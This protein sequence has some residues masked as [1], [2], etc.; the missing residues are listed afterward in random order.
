MKAVFDPAH[1]R[2]APRFFLVRGQLQ[3]STEQPERANRLLKGLE[4]AEI[5]VSPPRDFGTAPIEAVHSA[6]YLDFIKTAHQRWHELPNASEEVIANI[7][8]LQKAAKYPES[9]IG[10]AGWHMADTACPI[11]KY[12]W[13]AACGSANSALTATQLVLDGQRMSYA[14]CR[15]PGHHAYADMAGGFCFLNN[16]AIAAQYA[17]ATHAR[18]AILDVDV[19]HGNGTQGIFY[20]RDDVLTIS[21]HAD[22]QNF[23]PFYWGHASEKGA[24]QGVGFNRN[25]PLPLLSADKEFLKA[26]EEA[27]K[28]VLEFNPGILIIALGLDASETD[29]LR[30]LSVTTEG[31]NKIGKSIAEFSLPTVFIQEGGYLSD[32]LS[33]NLAAVL[34]GA[35]SGAQAAGD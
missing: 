21:I 28:T 27:K 17:R 3:E 5:Q 22:P 32:I 10:R 19:H 4:Q 35:Q 1:V 18:V 9:I 13:E 34:S 11:G 15:P 20:E 25:I 16:A 6:R 12:T 2:H 31:F 23:Y 33:A 26:I 14:L 30:G 29:P 7:H 8:P 24:G